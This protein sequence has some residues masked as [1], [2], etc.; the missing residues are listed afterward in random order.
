MNWENV[1]RLHSRAARQ[2]ADVAQTIAPADWP[3][4]LGPGKWSP[5]AV[6]EHVGMTMDVLTRELEGGEGMRVRTGWWQR[7]LLRWTILPKI[8]RGAGFP[9]GAP[10]PRE[11]R[12]GPLTAR[13]AA[14]DSAIA[15]FGDRVTRLEAAADAAHSRS[16]GQ[17]LTHAYF[18]RLSVRKGLL[19]NARHMQHHRTQLTGLGGGF[20]EPRLKPGSNS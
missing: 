5:A 7:M 6:L 8:F 13:Q 11:M 17:R 9:E 20:R 4:P 14:R 15:D 3:T 18:G 1:R 2:L 10:A 16:P 19:L 12:P